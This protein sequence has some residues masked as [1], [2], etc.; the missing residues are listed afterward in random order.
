[1]GLIVILEIAA[2]ILAIVYRGKVYCL[3]LSPYIL[4]TNYCPTTRRRVYC[5]CIARISQYMAST[6]L[7]LS[8]AC[9]YMHVVNY[10]LHVLRRGGPCLPVISEFR[11]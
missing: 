2:F 6:H 1:M 3:L 10:K 5:N 7:T 8:P 11:L 9:M 4:G